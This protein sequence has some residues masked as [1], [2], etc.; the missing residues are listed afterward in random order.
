MS[1][2]VLKILGTLVVAIIALWVVFTLAMRAKYAPVIDSVRRFNRSVGNPLA[3]ATA[4]QPGAYA[5]VITHRGRTS[6][7][8]YET[9]IGPFAS[10]D[11]FVIPLPYGATADWV[12]NVLAEG[13]AVIVTEG[14]VYHVDHPELVSSDDAMPEIPAKYQWSLRLYN[15]D[16]FLRVRTVA[17]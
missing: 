17:R 5:S 9:P 16:D 1:K 12:K 13:S 10:D 8:E 6:G 15:V 4:G 3:M 11:G 7:T 2:R 14:E